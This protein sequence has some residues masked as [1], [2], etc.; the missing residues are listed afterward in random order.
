MD[1]W[2]E[3]CWRSPHTD[4]GKLVKVVQIL[5]YRWPFLLVVASSGVLLFEMGAA[6]GILASIVY[7][8]RLWRQRDLA[9]RWIFF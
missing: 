2:M 8:L 1:C 3:W 9:S 6:L 5:R 4:S 7:S